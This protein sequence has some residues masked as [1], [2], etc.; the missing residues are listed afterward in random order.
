MSIPNVFV[1]D[2]DAA[3]RDSVSLLLET[4]G[5]PHRIFDSAEAFLRARLDSS[6][7][8]IILDV[9]M[10]GLS[11]PE[12]QA[13]LNERG[14]SLPIIFLTAHG[15]IPLTVRAIKAGAVD[16]LTKP[17]NGSVLLDRVQAALAQSVRLQEEASAQESLSR[18]M[19]N[20]T[21]R[22]RDVM[23]LAVAGHPNKEIARLLGISHRT[24]EIHRARVMHKTGATN[25]LELARIAESGG[26]KAA[27]PA[28]SEP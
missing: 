12:L 14:V 8:C 13:E 23:A 1:V 15:D 27:P 2:D 7:G 11:G 18:R 5:I 3:V 20:L 26:L 28:D 25:L 24:V 4:A 22:E 16:F 10:P 6:A 19:E 9:R 17:V 21:D